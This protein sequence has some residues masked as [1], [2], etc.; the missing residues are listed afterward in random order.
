VARYPSIKFDKDTMGLWYKP[1][2]TREEATQLLKDKEPGA[3][4]VRDS[5]SYDGAFGL[6]VK[7]ETP[8]IGVL[9]QVGG[10][11]TK[12][13]LDSELVRHFLIEPSKKGV[14]LKGSNNEPAFPSLVALI[15]QHTL[16]KMALPVPLV[17][18]EPDTDASRKSNLT[19]SQLLQK[20]AACNLVYLGTFDVESLTGDGAVHYAMNKATSQNNLHLKT[21]VINIKVN[22]QGITLTDNQRK[23]FFRR[24]YTMRDVLH[25][26]VDPKSRKINLKPIVEVDKEV[27]CFGF[28]VRKQTNSLEN[29][30]HLCAELDADQPASAVINF[31]HKAMRYA[32]HA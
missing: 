5:Q 27:G 30:C 11:I 14:R 25:C 10:D 13:D 32:L 8:P 12:I 24:H 22:Q 15:Y 3:F 29:E 19:E 20:G 4:V 23:L 16:T 17:I 1:K 18:P 7:V 21:T 2:L 6:A 26:G 28:V 31:I 9:Q